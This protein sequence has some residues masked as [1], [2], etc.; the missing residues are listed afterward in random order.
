MNS[1]K[2]T[3]TNSNLSLLNNESIISWNC[4]IKNIS[5]LK[6]DEIGKNYIL[7]KL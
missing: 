1:N 7:D 3:I 6:L 2:I 5:L 4:N